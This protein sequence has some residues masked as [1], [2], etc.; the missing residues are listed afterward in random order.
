MNEFRHVEPTISTAAKP[1]CLKEHEPVSGVT[2]VVAWI[3]T[4]SVY[5]RNPFPNDG[6]TCSS[7]RGIYAN[8]WFSQALLKRFRI[9][10]Q[11]PVC[12]LRVRSLYHG[13]TPFSQL[14]HC[15]LPSRM[16]KV[17]FK[18]FPDDS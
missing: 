15:Q 12:L 18:C 4:E 11:L 8:M 7:G 5:I 16:A 6:Y 13:L 10:A 14:L 1:D 2:V 3:V 9:G 17:H